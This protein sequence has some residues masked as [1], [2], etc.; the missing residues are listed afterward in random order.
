MRFSDPLD[1][2][3]LNGSWTDAWSSLGHGASARVFVKRQTELQSELLAAW[4]EPQRHYHDERH[5]RECLSL[6]QR[7]RGLA[8]RPAEL[9]LALWCHDAVYDPAATDNEL[10]S[11]GWAARAISRAGAGSEVAHRVHGLIM[12]TCHLAASSTPGGSVGEGGGSSDAADG[13]PAPGDIALLLDI[14]L[15]ILGS[16]PARFEQYDQAVRREH[17]QV[18]GHLYRLR[19]AAVLQSFLDRPAIYQTEE[20]VALLEAAARRNLAAAISRLAL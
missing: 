2:A 14:D 4:R 8:Q 17:A 5:L 12:A 11:A 13:V 18:P 7:W 9:A 3:V 15:A 1:D 16:P 19:R 20:A 10:Q 6:W